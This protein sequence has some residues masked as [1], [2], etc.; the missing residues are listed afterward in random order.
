MQTKIHFKC[1]YSVR[2]KTTHNP[3]KVAAAV[4]ICVLYVYMFFYSVYVVDATCFN[5]CFLFHVITGKHYFLQKFLATM[6]FVQP[7]YCCFIWNKSV[8]TL[9]LQ[10][11]ADAKVPKIKLS[12]TKFILDELLKANLF[13]GK[14]L[15]AWLFHTSLCKWFFVKN[16]KDLWK[17]DFTQ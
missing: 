7:P 6:R 5:E 9:S 3:S 16:S 10:C 8:F 14:V 15:Y 13:Y 4:C 12:Y 2:I 11:S 1:C 17:Y